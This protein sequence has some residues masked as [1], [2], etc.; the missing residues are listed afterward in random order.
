[1]SWSEARTQFPHSWVV[2]EAV[3]AYTEGNQRVVPKLT[4]LDTYGDD[5]SAAWSRYKTLKSVNRAGEYY[6][7]HTDRPL[8]DWCVNRLWSA[9]SC[10]SV[11]NYGASY[12]IIL[13][14]QICKRLRHY[15]FDLGSF[16]HELLVAITFMS[17]KVMEFSNKSLS[18]FMVVK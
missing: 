18:H 17:M 15:F 4:V 14:K 6:V 16:W 12:V 11:K 1:M 10:Q 5:F 7:V 2:L 8:L 13:L 3:G 9:V